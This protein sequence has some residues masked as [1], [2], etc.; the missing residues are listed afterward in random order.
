MLNENIAYSKS[1]LNKYGI[2]LDSP[3]YADYL[4][5]REIVGNDNGYV[6]IL[7]KLRFVDSVTDIDELKS[8]YEIL[9]KSKFD[10]AKLNKL[11]YEQI[12]DMF[13]DELSGDKKN[14][15]NYE[16]ILRDD[17]Y[18]YYKVY[19]Y[20]GILDIGSPAWCLKTKSNWDAY[21]A[22]YPN[23]YVIID[24]RYIKR[25][26]SPNNN[27]LK[28]YI[29]NKR[30]IRYGLSI[31]NNGDGTF[32]YIGNDD[33][34]NVIKNDISNYTSWGIIRTVLNLEIGIIKPYYEYFT[35][36]T[37]TKFGS[38]RLCDDRALE[39]MG[40]KDHPGYK[41]N[42]EVYVSFS[43]S[44]SAMPVFLIFNSTY[45][46]GF[47]PSKDEKYNLLYADLVN[48]SA[49]LL[50]D[51]ASRHLD[52]NLYSGLNYKNNKLTLDNIKS[53]PEFI[54]IIDDK[55]VVYDHNN[56]YMIVNLSPKEYHIT[57]TTYKKVSHP[58]D[59]AI[60][61]YIDKNTFKPMHLDDTS[62]SDPI[63]N[64]LRTPISDPIDNKNILKRFGDFVRGK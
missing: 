63:V 27:Y 39:I 15:T 44:Y 47:F 2:S 16:L 8:I 30:Y 4:K 21:Q 36:V 48:N 9:K 6:G 1:I 17:T 29:S 10:F 56:Y 23:Q 42:N 22:K 51:Y 46:L 49:K 55:W 40:V 19:T 57:S 43:K 20:D 11:T 38:W 14:K 34:N 62:I 58:E 32:D 3:E 7:T 31:K 52:Y 25:I 28:N 35:G 18:S 24:N 12:L 45:P 26:I 50:D 37:N 41:S 54:V 60:Y 13:Y 64:S 59:D 53:I 5:I 33:N 61:F